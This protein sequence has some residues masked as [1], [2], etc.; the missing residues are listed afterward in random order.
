MIKI[1]EIVKE[2]ESFFSEKEF[3]NK[4]Y[5][6]ILKQY[7][8]VEQEIKE[9]KD[10]E[11]DEEVKNLFEK[12]K[13]QIKKIEKKKEEYQ[14]WKEQQGELAVV[15]KEKLCEVV[16]SLVEIEDRAL[17]YRLM[18][19]ARQ[20]WMKIGKDSSDPSKQ[21]SQNFVDGRFFN[22]LKKCKEKC[23]E[24]ISSLQGNTEEN[25]QKKIA[26]IEKFK[27]LLAKEVEDFNSIKKQFKSILDE[28]KSIK[29]IPEG[30]ES[31][32]DDF[33]EL[34]TQYHNKR[35][36]LEKKQKVD[37]EEIVSKKERCV[38]QLEDLKNKIEKEKLPWQKIE[39]T[40]QE[41]HKKWHELPR[42]DFRFDKKKN[43]KKYYQGLESILSLFNLGRDRVTKLQKESL[44][45]LIEILNKEEN[46]PSQTYEIINLQKKIKQKDPLR[47]FLNTE[48]NKTFKKLTN[49]FFDKNKE[50]INLQKEQKNALLEEREQLQ[51]QLNEIL[52]KEY[53]YKQVGDVKKISE[54]F[55]D[56]KPPR[57]KKSNTIYSQFKESLDSFY[58]KKNKQESNFFLQNKKNIEK[59][60]VLIFRLEK[61]L[62][63]NDDLN[64]TEKIPLARKLQTI[65]KLNQSKQMSNEK[66]SYFEIQEIK[67]EWYNMKGGR[68]TEDKKLFDQF[69]NLLDQYYKKKKK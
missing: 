59:K 67:K 23:E 20:K 32:N 31:I 40:L 12:I 16:E 43:S 53:H 35:E 51:Q 22:A 61:L 26:L 30:K 57:S 9:K 42:L 54:N 52:K 1:T 24:Y 60:K 28:W 27:N 8:V 15:K 48:E 18:E 6:K 37:T 63:L 49:D 3:N 50:A 33:K 21:T 41:M 65:L 46:I 66:S 44:E 19:E 38:I 10:E 55:F 58:L 4:K 62:N 14:K 36:Y 25:Y 39:N 64:E 5:F 13:K 17:L 34:L 7:N 68:D 56:I 29:Y 45:K 69:K 11:I 2:I 47:I